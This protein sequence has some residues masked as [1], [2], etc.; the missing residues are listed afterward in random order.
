MSFEF[1]VTSFEL[2][3]TSFRRAVGFIS[4]LYSRLRFSFAPKWATAR[5]HGWSGAKPVVPNHPT[6]PPPRQGRRQHLSTPC[7]PYAPS[8][9]EVRKSLQNQGFRFAPPLATC[10]DSFGVRRPAWSGVAVN[11]MSGPVQSSFS[12]DPEGSGFHE[13]SESL[14]NYGA[15]L[16][17]DTATVQIRLRGNSARSWSS[18]SS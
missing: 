13:I 18:R 7:K 5:S 9:A 17:S 2:R 1:R 11:P 16:S 4:C 10:L 15:S 12:R 6:P 8:G 3:V 14:R